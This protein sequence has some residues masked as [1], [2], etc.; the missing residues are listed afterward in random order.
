VLLWCSRKV[1]QG[2][3][4][5]L[6]LSPCLAPWSQLGWSNPRFSSGYLRWS[7][8][9]SGLWSPLVGASLA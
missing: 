7:Q 3:G 9:D 2:W 4:V 5:T 1:A 6:L 8:L